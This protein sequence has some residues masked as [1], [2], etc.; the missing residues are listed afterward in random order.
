[1][2]ARRFEHFSEEHVGA[3][4]VTA[5]LAALL[6]WLVRRRP[7]AEGRVR[8]ALAVVLL[9]CSA[10]YVVVEASRGSV[11]LAEVVPLQLCDFALFV[12]AYALLRR[13]QRTAELLYFWAGSAALLAMVTP[14][15]TRPF[16]DWYFLSY[17]VLHGG[18]LV[19]AATLV[20]GCGMTPTRGA[21]LR[22]LAWTNAYGLA[23]GAINLTF[24]TNY[25]YLCRKPSTATMLDWFGPWPVYLLVGELV[26][27]GGFVLLYLPFR[28]RQ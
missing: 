3:F 15:L 9:G 19:A 23:L 24:D 4:A 2:A 13:G 5:V 14:D 22:A 7:E 25:L 21:P 11:A 12:G 20:F 16:P 28:G 10:A 1:M 27:M 18:L 26:A 17:F 6:V 8:V